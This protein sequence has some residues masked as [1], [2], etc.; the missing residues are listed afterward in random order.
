MLSDRKFFNFYDRPDL[1]SLKGF[2]HFE[3]EVIVEMRDEIFKNSKVKLKLMVSD[4]V[5]KTTNEF[6][7]RN[8]QPIVEAFSYEQYAVFERSQRSNPLRNENELL[9]F[10]EN[11]QFSSFQL[12]S[13][14]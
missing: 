3:P 14:P 11:R 2:A 1:P 8:E 9:S 7:A 13:K 10:S 6:V 12:I 4:T 5:F